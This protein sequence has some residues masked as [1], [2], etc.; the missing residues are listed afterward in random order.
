MKIKFSEL[1]NSKNAISSYCRQL[2]EEGVHPRTKLEIYRNHETPDIICK[3]IGKAA[4]IMVRENVAVGPLFVKYEKM[5]PDT[6][7]KIKRTSEG[8]VA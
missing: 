2:I 1:P 8:D 5:D 3:T 7:K 4:R 6:K